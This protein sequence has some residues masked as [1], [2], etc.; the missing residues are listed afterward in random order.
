MTLDELEACVRRYPRVHAPPRSLAFHDR[1][2]LGWLEHGLTPSDIATRLG[3][4]AKRVSAR[5][6]ILRGL[7]VSLP[8]GEPIPTFAP[9]KLSSDDD[10]AVLKLWN[11]GLSR[12]QVAKKLRRTPG[13]VMGHIW[14][15]RRKGF[16]VR[17]GTAQPHHMT[18]SPKRALSRTA[19]NLQRMQTL[20]PMDPG[21]DAAARS[22]V[23]LEVGQCCWPYATT[24][25]ASHCGRAVAKRGFC[26]IHV[27]IAYAPKAEKS[28]RVTSDQRL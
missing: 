25:P 28:T 24:G 22:L 13:A 11:S 23:D 18:A 10:E 12:T 7:G 3:V 2:I 15:L 20:H 19:P 6:F 17:E 9:R 14:R 27:S 26:A 5:M 4:A 21:P 16:D 1:T 8:S